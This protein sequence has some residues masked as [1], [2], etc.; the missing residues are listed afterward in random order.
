MGRISYT[1]SLLSALFALLAL[2]GCDKPA[3]SD[4]PTIRLQLGSK[5]FTLEV[6]DRTDTR[7]TGLMR[8]DSIPE[9]HGMIFVF[10]REEKLG[11]WMK[12]TRIPL[13]IVYLDSAGKI[14]SIKSMKP[15]DL[16]T[17]PSDHPAKFAIELNKG[18]ANAAGLKPGM[19]V[20]LPALS[21]KN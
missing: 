15:Y 19:Q 18:Q 12:N 4:L 16:D 14:V 3:Q 7:T 9:D 5:S 1:P 17:T 2:V 8:R 20:N 11:F 13:D 10:D 21:A 6:A